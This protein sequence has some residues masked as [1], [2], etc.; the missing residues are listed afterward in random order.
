MYDDLI[1]YNEYRNSLIVDIVNLFPNKQVLVL[2]DRIVHGEIL[3][4]GLKTI[5]KDIVYIHGKLGKKKRRK[6]VE[7][8]KSSKLRVVVASKIFNESV[9]V[10]CIDVVVD[11]TN[12]SSGIQTLQK[13][14]RALRVSE[15]KDK[16]YLISFYDYTYESLRRASAKRIRDL[17][18]EGHNIIVGGIDDIT[19]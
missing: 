15:G 11:A 7:D 19:Y 14:G 8:F 9:D 2:V 17:R 18:K 4:E 5:Y 10:P 1:V 3:V 16:A 13:L 12:I 6:Y